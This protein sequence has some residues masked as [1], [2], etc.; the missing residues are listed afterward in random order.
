MCVTVI[1]K[2]AMPSARLIFIGGCGV[3]LLSLLTMFLG[4][5]F[6]A[7]LET[8]VIPPFIIATG[9]IL[10]TALVASMPVWAMF[11][12]RRRVVTFH[13]AGLAAVGYV[14]GFAGVF[15]AAIAARFFA[16][17]LNVDGWQL[18]AL[19]VAG[20]PVAAYLAGAALW[21]FVRLCTGPVIYGDDDSCLG[22]G[23]T[24]IG[25][26][27]GRCPE[28]GRA[29]TNSTTTPTFAAA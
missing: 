29:F 12:L 11:R 5:V 20:G 16:A 27:S 7:S 2:D 4:A 19:S 17:G 15:P 24:L 1:R 28:C 23:Y 22:C 10:V 18:V 13:R 3:G 6:I 8:Y 26:E 25:C 14:L 21:V 9:L